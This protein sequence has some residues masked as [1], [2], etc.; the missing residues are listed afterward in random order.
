MNEGTGANRSPVQGGVAEALQGSNG[1]AGAGF[2][3]L[4]HVG[5]AVADLEEAIDRY[6]N[7][8]GMRTAGVEENVEQGVREAVMAFGPGEGAYLQLLAPLSPDS[9][10]SHFLGRS[11]PGVQQVA[12]TVRDLDTA[13]EVL[14]K[15]GV[16]LLYE[17]AGRG[18][19]D[20]RVNFVHPSDTGGV[21]MELVEKK[22]NRP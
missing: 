12:V 21:L 14:R 13:T 11:G 10:I 5:L 4:D 1:A 18:T 7:V 3:R 6:E 8:F 17:E 19:G 9:P 16:R 2:L 20:T 22:E 15:Q